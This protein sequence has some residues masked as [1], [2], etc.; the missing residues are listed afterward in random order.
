MFF[1][2]LSLRIQMALRTK[3]LS[4][5]IRTAIRRMKIGLLVFVGIIVVGVLIIIVLTFVF[6]NQSNAAGILD[7]VESVRF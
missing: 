5:D 1:L 4:T 7:T 3:R 2:I 6:L